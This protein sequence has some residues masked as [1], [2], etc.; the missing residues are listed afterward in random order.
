MR[1]TCGETMK[2]C[3]VLFW[4]L[5]CTTWFCKAYIYGDGRFLSQTSNCSSSGFFFLSFS[6][7]FFL[8][9]FCFVFSNAITSTLNT[10]DPQARS[11]W[12]F[13][14]VIW[15]LWISARSISS[16][17]LNGIRWLP[18][19]ETSPLCLGLKPSSRLSSLVGPFHKPRQTIP[20][21]IDH[22]YDYLCIMC[23][24]GVCL[25]NELLFCKMIY[26]S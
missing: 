2:V 23:V 14:N 18:V 11:F 4:L 9:L 12:K 13:Q 17:R 19:C 20:L 3:I 5:P 7:F 8:S 26:A 10:H 21:T 15:N 22:V 24:N 6:F 1:T 16:L 25:C